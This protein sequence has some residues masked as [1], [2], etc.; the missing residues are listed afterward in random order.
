MTTT[1]SSKGQVV[2]PLPVRQRQKLRAGD[3]LFLFE[4]SNGDIILRRA[5]A[6]KKSLAWH[7]RRLRGLRIPRR[8]EFLR[9][10]NW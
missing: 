6:P 7:L 10:V 5:R 4:L 9:E 8:R 2:I 3:D 1:L